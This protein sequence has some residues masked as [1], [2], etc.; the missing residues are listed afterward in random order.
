MKSTKGSKINDRF[1]GNRTVSMPNTNQR[2]VV[3][4]N[5]NNDDEQ[6][7]LE[8]KRSG[9]FSFFEQQQQLEIQRTKL[10]NKTNINYGTITTQ[11]GPPNKKPSKEDNKFTQTAVSDV[12]GGFGLFQFL[13]LLFS[14]LRECLVGYDA[15]IMSV[16]FQPEEEFVCRD[17][18]RPDQLLDLHPSRE[19]LTNMMKMSRLNE[20]LQCFRSLD[21]VTP[22]KDQLTGQPVR[23]ESWLFADETLDNGPSLVAEW[24]L[25]CHN[26]WLVA[27]IES[28]YFFGL[29]T[30]NLCWGYCA[31][32]FGRRPAYLMAHTIALIFG[33]LA[34][35]TPSSIWIF[36]LCRY[37]AAF[38]SIGYNII[39]SIQVEIIGA[40]HRSFCTILN[41]AGWGLGV[42]FVPIVD[43][44]FDDYRPIIA[45]API[46]TL[47]M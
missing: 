41:H 27:F 38:G 1:I 16:I 14:G 2:H 15:L 17:N 24:E 21:G 39:Y 31:D 26:H 45:V 7:D 43:H 22:L 8:G 20:T 5:L 10:N 23:C 25:V 40:K 46:F 13:V 29:V 30:G 19:N 3:V 6:D 36:A 4:S 18:L 9:V 37:L 28:A 12:V 35:I 47:L 42:I 11:N 44:L 33:S 34:V 32:K